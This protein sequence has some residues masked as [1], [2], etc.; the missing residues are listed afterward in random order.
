MKKIILIVLV[1]ISTIS[2]GGREDGSDRRYI[3]EELRN[4]KLQTER[5]KD[6]NIQ[7]DFI[8]NDN[9]SK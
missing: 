5:V 3:L 9:I 4:K 6:K 2:Y 8:K 7:N 1:T